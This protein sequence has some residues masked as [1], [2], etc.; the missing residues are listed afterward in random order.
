MSRGAIR[1]AGPASAA[2]REA[3]SA[4]RLLLVDCDMYF[5]QVAQ[6]EDPDGIGRAELVLVGGRAGSRG[7]VT[8]ASYPCR[9]FG[10]RSGMPTSQALRLCPNATLVPVPREACSRRSREIRVVLE[11]FAPVVEA[12][13]ID[14]FYLDL[15]GTERLYRDETLADTARRIQRAVRER[16]GIAV[17]IGGGTQR[18]IAKMATRLA[19]PNGVHLVAAGGE[20]EFML[21]WDLADIPGVGPVLARALD[22][23][24]ARSVRDALGWDE[25][26]LCLW[27][28]ERRGR[29]LFERVR[30][31]DSTPV[32]PRGDPKSV[33]HEHTFAEDVFAHPDLETE[34]LRLVTDLAADLRRKGLRA[35]TV[36]V[37]LRDHDWND[38]QASRTLPE[39][40]AADRPLVEV[41]RAL[42][43]QLWA[44]RAVGARLIGVAATGFAPHHE[45]EQMR[46]LDIAPPLETERDRNLAAAADQLRA[47]FGHA[48][49]LPA[50]LIGDRGA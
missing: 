9:A 50:R 49:V 3:A 11:R 22:R 6:L 4:R 20:A 26:G 1:G 10:V 35:K 27:L 13:S 46:L 5:V 7:V 29:W 48:A 43:G 32:Q 33:S 38:R 41:A 34:L 24:G 28:G 44:E 17:S 36:R 45:P 16:T 8:S 14:E 19:K 18:M 47:R 37:Y 2:A 25:A 12:A 21:R 42:L 23:R 31:I 15:S 30:G 39:R 40:I